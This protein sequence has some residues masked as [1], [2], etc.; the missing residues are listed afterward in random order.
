MACG[1][2]PRSEHSRERR[3]EHSRERRGEH[4]RE[5]GG[6]ESIFAGTWRFVKI[7][8]R[9]R[10][11]T[12]KAS[13]RVAPSS[14]S[15]PFVRFSRQRLAVRAPASGQ[16]LPALVLQARYASRAPR[17]YNPP[18]R[19]EALQPPTVTPPPLL[20]HRYAP[21]RAP[22]AGDSASAFAAHPADR[23][24]DAGIFE[25]PMASGRAI[26]MRS[27]TPGG[28]TSVAVACV[29]RFRLWN[30]AGVEPVL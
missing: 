30:P 26:R 28:A 25:R 17:R 12:N 6:G 1:I 5:R 29:R 23:S 15:T 9:I 10:A 2:S 20:R 19:P 18:P 13:R 27:R 7:R 11:G 8:Q 22:G 24:G 14:L 21:A 3:G 4:S 16:S